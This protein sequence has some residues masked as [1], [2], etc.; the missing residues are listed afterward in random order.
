M[1]RMRLCW[2][3]YGP[4]SQGTAEHFARHLDEF[5]AKHALTGCAT[6]TEVVGPMHAFAH[7]RAEGA[8]LE[9]LKRALRPKRTED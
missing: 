9:T 2:D 8:A 1:H 3:F 6:G 5:I 7:C 4:D